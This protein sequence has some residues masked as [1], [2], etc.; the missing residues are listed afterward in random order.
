MYGGKNGHE[1]SQW[2]NGQRP[3]FLV[4]QGIDDAEDVDG[5]L[6]VAAVRTLYSAASLQESREKFV[7]GARAGHFRMS[8]ANSRNRVGV[9]AGNGHFSKTRCEIGSLAVGFRTHLAVTRFERRNIGSEPVKIALV[10]APGQPG[11]NV[12]HAEEK[13]PLGEIHHQGNEVI[14]A[15][16]KLHMVTLA[17]IIGADVHLCT[18]WD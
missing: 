17:N 3:G 4:Q 13:S 15:A 14:A 1:H 11:E 8:Q 2:R 10:A 6:R 18:G 9:A 5:E 12:V 7:H 16:L